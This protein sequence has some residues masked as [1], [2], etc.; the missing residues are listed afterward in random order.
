MFY[1]ILDYNKKWKNDVFRMFY[2]MV[3]HLVDKYAFKMLDF[4]NCG[5]NLGQY[6]DDKTIVNKILIIEN[7]DDKLLRDYFDD[8]DVVKSYSNL[9]L[10]SDDIH[11]GRERKIETRYY[12]DF[13]QIYVTYYKP[14][15][16]LYP[17]FEYKE[18]VVW[19]PHCVEDSM[20]I[21][22]NNNPIMKIGL[23]GMITKTHYPNRESFRQLSKKDRYK[24]LIDHIEHPN[25]KYRAVNYK[26]QNLVIGNNYYNMLNKYLCNFTCSGSIFYGFVVCK[27]FEIAYTGSLLL[28]DQSSDDLSELGFFDGVNCI[29]YQSKDEIEN[30]LN[31]IFSNLDKINEIRY[32]GYKLIRE[33]HLVSI[34]CLEIYKRM[35]EFVSC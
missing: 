27:Y 6:I 1:V 12:Y 14:F 16:Q 34:R 13:N 18:R 30:K 33:K 29:I 8:I 15:F 23:F 25:R 9:F 7:H 21:D 4:G 3:N 17:D 19:T 35:C 20:N 22:F 2:Y 24:D 28:C 31:Y 10:F 26:N 5:K 11:K 32:N